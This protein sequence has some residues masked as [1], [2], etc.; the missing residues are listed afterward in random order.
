[1]AKVTIGYA[2]CPECD[3]VQAVESDRLKYLIHCTEC[4]TFTHYQTKAAKNRIEQKLLPDMTDELEPIDEPE[5][6]EPENTSEPESQPEEASETKPETTPV[7]QPEKPKGKRS[8]LAMI[9]Q[10][11]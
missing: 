8:F 5:A 4:L 1:M 11:L 3:S 2:H 10:Y 6:L 7:E 9:G